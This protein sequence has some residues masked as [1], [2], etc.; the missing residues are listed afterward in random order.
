MQKEKKIK[1]LLLSNM[2]SEKESYFGIFVKDQVES[3]EKLGVNVIKVVKTEKSISGYVPFILKSILY[4][5]FKSYNIVHAHYGFHSGLIAAII[6]RKPLVITFHRGDALDEPWRNKAYYYAQKFVVNRA[7]HIIA[8]SNEVKN[9]LMQDLDAKMGKI[10][11]ISC[12]VDTEFFKPMG[13]KH[14]LR[15]RLNLPN[16]KALAL[17]VGSLSYRKGVDIIYKCAE[18]LPEIYFVFVGEGDLKT[19]LPN[20]IFVGSKPHHEIRLWMNASDLFLLPSRSEGLPVV[21]LEACSCEIPAI[22]SAVGGI[23][24]LINNGGN[25]V[26]IGSGNPKDYVE[27]IEKLLSDIKRLCSIGKKA[28]E[29]VERNYDILVI[30]NKV[31][32]IYE[33]F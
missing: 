14:K 25:G 32:R 4:L 12:G 10:T 26:L 9:A 13:D 22:A 11:L 21:L 24:E 17:F 20:C 16:G 7:T 6:R 28:R 30:G 18:L 3:L 27:K 29:S 31:K 2:Y 15:E 1:I 8:I 19:D 5:L 33:Q 23:P